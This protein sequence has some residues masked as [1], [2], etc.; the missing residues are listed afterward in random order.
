M[1]RSEITF[2]VRPV[3]HTPVKPLGRACSLNHSD[4]SPLSISNLR[5]RIKLTRGELGNTFEYGAPLTSTSSIAAAE[6][7]RL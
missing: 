7:E 2:Y 3:S 6:R 1:S 4:I 5:R